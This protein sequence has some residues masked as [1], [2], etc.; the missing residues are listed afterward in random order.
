MAIGGWSGRSQDLKHESALPMALIGVNIWHFFSA[1]SRQP[2]KAFLSLLTSTL[3]LSDLENTDKNKRWIL[4]SLL[5]F[6]TCATEVKKEYKD[7]T[8]QHAQ[9]TFRATT[10]KDLAIKTAATKHNILPLS[11]GESHFISHICSVLYYFPLWPSYNSLIFFAANFGK[12]NQ[13]WDRHYPPSMAHCRGDK[14][15]WIG[16][17]AFALCLIS[18]CATRADEWPNRLDVPLSLVFLSTRELRARP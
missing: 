16:P 13:R 15:W 12:A 17:S 11:T 3:I 10:A 14:H 18:H 8:L 2:E 9:V 6:Q 4:F 7:L 1:V 5:H